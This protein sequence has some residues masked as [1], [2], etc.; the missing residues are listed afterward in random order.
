MGSA[1]QPFPAGTG[2]ID[3]GA[4]RDL[5]ALM[6]GAF[7]GAADSGSAYVGLRLCAPLSPNARDHRWVGF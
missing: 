4:A 7:G 6:A 2:R 5:G 3:F 1:Q